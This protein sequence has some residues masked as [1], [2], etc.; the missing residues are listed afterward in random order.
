MYQCRRKWK[1]YK[2]TQGWQIIFL[3]NLKVNKHFF[4]HPYRIHVKSSSTKR[5][6]EAFSWY[7]SPSPLDLGAFRSCRNKCR[8]LK[9]IPRLILFFSINKQRRIQHH[10]TCSFP[11]FI[12]IWCSS[13]EAQSKYQSHNATLFNPPQFQITLLFLPILW[14]TNLPLE[15]IKSNKDA[16]RRARDTWEK[17]LNFQ[18]GSKSKSL[19]P[20]GLGVTRFNLF[21]FLSI[22]F[23]TRFLFL[24]TIMSYISLSII[25]KFS[26]VL[27]I[28]T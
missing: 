20:S 12:Y 2:K 4:I 7:N 24:P 5:C 21:N 13:T 15:L 1:I 11:N 9:R 19:E 14:V 6:R 25:S 3:S 16:I 8:T 23:S 18:V 27:S 26:T 10:I 17:H 28:S 22:R